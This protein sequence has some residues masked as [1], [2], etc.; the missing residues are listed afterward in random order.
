MAELVVMSEEVSGVEGPHPY[1]QETRL[2]FY[3]LKQLM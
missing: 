2:P 3:Y 1:S